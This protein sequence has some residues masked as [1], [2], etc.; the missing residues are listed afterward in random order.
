M[1][2]LTETGSL[3]GHSELLLSK[4]RLDGRFFDSGS[5]VVHRFGRCEVRPACREALV[6]GLL[7]SLQPRPFDLLLYLIEHRHRVVSVDELLDV[8]WGSQEV[9]IN[10]VAT[11]IA[12][13]RSVLGE[14]VAGNGKLIQTCHRVGYRF[15]ATL[16]EGS[17]S[18]VA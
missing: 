15:V 16:E 10:S 2:M 4:R 5:T 6:D 7:R 11:A 17:N 1:L 14:G 3:L 12:R 18:R 9:Q 8:I 13:I